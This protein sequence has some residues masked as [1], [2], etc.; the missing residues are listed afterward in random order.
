MT[1]VKEEAQA[2]EPLQ[3]KNI[4]D[5]DVVDCSTPLETREGV[6]KDGK[7]FTYKVL[8]VEGEDYRVPNKVIGD[9]KA[10][11]EKKP[12]LQK[13][14]VSKTGTGMGTKYTVIPML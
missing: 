14:S 8:V 11:L 9:L 6:D 5:L 1:T 13:F 10:I 12:D 4:A 2:Y 7:S 3:V